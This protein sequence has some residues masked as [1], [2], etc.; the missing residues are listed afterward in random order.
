MSLSHPREAL[1][2]W[3]HHELSVPSETIKEP[4]L[5]TLQGIGW[6]ALTGLCFASVTGIVRYLGS[7]LPAV[8][9]AF[10]RYVIGLGLL[11]PVFFRIVKVSLPPREVAGFAVRGFVH[12]LGVI[13]WFFAMARIPMAEVTAIGYVTPIFVTVG[14]AF[15]LGEQLHARRLAGVFAG[16]L[17]ALV[18]LRPGFQDVSIG[19]LAQLLAAP[20]FAT[21]FLM[22]KSMTRRSD[23]G[24]IVAMLSLFCTLTLLPGAIMVWRTPT[25]EEVLWLALTAVFA[26]IGH[27]T[28]TQALK[29]APIAVTQPVTFLQLVWASLLGIMLFGEPVDPYVVLGSGMIVAAATYISHRETIAA[30]RQITPPSVATKL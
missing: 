1:H 5:K 28:M 21:S 30:R 4:Q 3:K 17:G 8:E 15:F 26:T 25:M 7:D 2:G 6:M 27:F 24:I 19:Q 14:A 16:L 18:I 23:P 22:A 10:L 13:L 29:A 20:M 9:A 11:A 12:G